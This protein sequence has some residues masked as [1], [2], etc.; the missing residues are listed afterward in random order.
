VWWFSE[1]LLKRVACQSPICFLIRFIVS[2]LDLFASSEAGFDLERYTENLKWFTQIVFVSVTYV[3]PV[4]HISLNC[5]L[6]LIST[7]SVGAITLSENI[8]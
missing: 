7:N 1:V 8:F 4:S 5:S 3:E 2:L 6:I